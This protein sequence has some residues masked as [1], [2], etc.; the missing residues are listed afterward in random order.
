MEQLSEA[1]AKTKFNLSVIDA[2]Y[3]RR[4]VRHYTKRQ[5]S[6]QAIEEL[7]NAAIQAPSAMNRQPWAFVIIQNIPLLNKIC[8][9]AKNLL[10]KSPEWR[11][12]S[13]HG[14]TPFAERGFDIFYEASTL[15]T[16]CAEKEGFQPVGDCYLAAEN[17]MLAAPAM[18]LATCPIGFARD[19]L[20]MDSFKAELGI[21]DGYDPVLPVIV[22]YSSGPT[23]GPPRNPPRILNWLT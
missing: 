9:E 20:K 11:M 7:I 12:N 17:L 23:E 2:I 22:G 13:E 4:S 1:A 3:A 21:P 19:V 8:Q 14:K 16:V 6:K 15:I 10:L 5:V 18:G